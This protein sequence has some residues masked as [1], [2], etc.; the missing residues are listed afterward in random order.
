MSLL[1]YDSMRRRKVRFEPLQPG[2]VG[3]YVCGVTVYDHCHV[4]HARVLVA[5]DVIVRVLRALGYEVHYVRNITDVDDK[6]LARAEDTGEPWQELGER[7]IRSMDRDCALLGVLPPDLQPRATASIA[8][9]IR[10]IERLIQ[11]DHAYATASGDVYFAVRSFPQYG[12][13]SGRSLDDMLVGARVTPDENKR[14]PCDFALWK[15]AADGVGW[16]APWGRGRPGWHIECSAMSTRCLGDSFDIHGGGPD[17]I[18]PHHENEI[19]QSEAATGQPFARWWMHAGAVQAAASGEKM[20]K[21][22]GNFVAIREAL[23]QCH[24]EVL[25]YLLLSSHYRSPIDYGPALLL[26]ARA[27]LSKLYRTLAQLPEAPPPSPL[28]RDDPWVQ[29][30]LACLED[31]FNVPQALALMFDVARQLNT[32]A[33]DSAMQARCGGVLAGCGAVLGLLGEQPQQ[34]LQSSAAGEAAEQHWDDAE[35]MRRIAARDRA[36]DDRDYAAAD[37]IRHQLEAAG[38]VLEDRPDG[39]VWRR[40]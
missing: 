32:A 23:Q 1:I 25:R 6:I 14:D 26:N 10:M 35:I 29:R 31:D 40:S 39:T 37:R 2:R 9:M 20:S 22:S 16:E 11:S 8:D 19:A 17:L 13:L 5:F 28:N 36:R 27:A 15:A 30:F 34:F 12:R 33:G 7:F 21:S 4:G 38:V 3:L 18:F 24:P